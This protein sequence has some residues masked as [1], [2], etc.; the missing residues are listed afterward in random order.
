MSPETTM[1]TNK[2]W[3]FEKFLCFS[4]EFTAICLG[5]FGVVVSGVL[6]VFLTLGGIGLFFIDLQEGYKG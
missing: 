5:W 3:P 6:I 1:T 4:L 2:F